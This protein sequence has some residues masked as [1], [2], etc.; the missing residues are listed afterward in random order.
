MA[1]NNK[2]ITIEEIKELQTKPI[3]EILEIAKQSVDKLKNLCS[4]INNIKDVF[5]VNVYNTNKTAFQKAIDVYPNLLNDEYAK[6]HL[7]EIKDSMIKKYKAG[8]LQVH[9]KY[10][11]ILPDFY[12][13][14][15][16]WFM[17]IENPK[18]LLKDGEVFCWLFR[19]S[20]NVDCLRSPHLY[21]EHAVRK[22]IAWYGVDEARR[23]WL[24]E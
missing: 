18:G 9:G 19:K 6:F 15:Q 2:K 1:K 5:G 16:Y 10:T 13:A 14:C 22:N 8:K 24:R 4:S 17:G 20:E 3:E 12:A 21:R 11:F 7:R 23:S